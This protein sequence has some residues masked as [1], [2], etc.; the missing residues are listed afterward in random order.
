MPPNSPLRRIGS[1]AGVMLSA[2]TLLAIWAPIENAFVSRTWR[3]IS[4]SENP[5]PTT[6]TVLEQRATP[7]SSVTSIEEYSP[8]NACRI[9]AK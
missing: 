7:L 9:L 4:R 6:V 5:M 1:A 2:V 3:N 8:G